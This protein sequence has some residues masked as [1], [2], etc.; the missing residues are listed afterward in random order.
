MKIKRF[1]LEKRWPFLVLGIFI[2]LTLAFL[3]HISSQK[4]APAYSKPSDQV[5]FQKYFNNIKNLG[6]ESAYIEFQNEAQ[7]IPVTTRHKNAHLFGEALYASEGT[8]GV[9]VCDTQFNYGCYHSFLGAAIQNEGI[10]IIPLLNDKCRDNLEEKGNSCPHGIGHGILSL[11]GYDFDNLTKSLEICSDLKLRDPY[12]GCLTGV[13]M[14][15]FFHNMILDTGSIKKYDPAHP[16]YPCY[17]VEGKYRQACFFQ[18][19]QWWLEAIPGKIEQRVTT[20]N[21]LCTEVTNQKNQDECYRGL[22]LI[23]L[24][25]INI[26]VE[27]G[28]KICDSLSSRRASLNCR[29]GETIFLSTA[30][31]HL[32][33]RAPELCQD[34]KF[35]KEEQKFCFTQVGTID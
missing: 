10:E 34:S 2:L 26:D 12:K 31:S 17:Q 23:V 25:F 20:V 27:Y 16:Y 15:Y 8:D 33:H 1:F 7:L 30:A 21:T 4:K 11:I 14:E 5:A 29:A 35:T 9:T 19:S 13:F 32:K 18:L 6:G 28:K 3:T 24:S 22:G